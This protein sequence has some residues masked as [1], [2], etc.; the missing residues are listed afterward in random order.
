VKGEFERTITELGVAIRLNPKIA[1]DIRGFAFS[2]VRGMTTY[3]FSTI[4]DPQGNSVAAGIND[5]NQIVGTYY[6][7]KGVAHGFSDSGGTYT[8][9][10]DPLGINGTYAYGISNAGNIIG[11][12]IDKNNT[13]QSFTYGHI[14]PVETGYITYNAGTNT[15]TELFGIS[16]GGLVGSYKDSN[17]T[18]H[19]ILFNGTTTPIMLSDP[20]GFNGTFPYGINDA[21][22]SVG[23]YADF[24]NTT[25][26]FLYSGGTYTTLDDPLGTNGT[27]AYGINDAGQIV[28]TYID[29]NNTPHGF[30]YSGGTYT[31]LDDPSGMMYGTTAFGINDA[32]QIVG[33]YTDN[34]G[35]TRGFLANPSSAT[36]TSA[37]QMLT[38]LYVGYFDRAPDVSGLN[39][40][41]NAY[42]TPPA[43]SPGG[44]NPFYQ[45]LGQAAASFA[46]PHQTETVTLYPFLANPQAASY[47]DVVTFLNA[48]YENLFNRA[49]DTVGEEY[50][51]TSI[52]KSLGITVPVFGNPVID[53]DGPVSASQ[54]LLA[55]ILGA[56]GNDTQTIANKVTA[57]LAYYDLLAANNVSATQTSAHAALA[58]VTFDPATVLTSVATTNAFV[59]SALQPSAASVSLVGQAG[60]SVLDHAVGAV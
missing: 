25:H 37:Q 22:Q 60:T 20:F 51:A 11:Q 16:D 4:D 26:G 21:G 32:G 48:A 15:T 29:S 13:L 14:T 57:G 52:A 23:Y 24:N 2:G 56:Q 12:Y 30:L 47:S 9:L 49:P 6:D 42:N 50:W 5:A 40:W 38:E 58:A 10:D 7:S 28:G 31:T 8:P 43:Q 1:D 39:Y 35:T 45:N 33:Q 18:S 36:I 54:A 46:D 53:N 17:N 59:Q 19:A 44:A 34:N 27:F 55:L 41:L 3:T